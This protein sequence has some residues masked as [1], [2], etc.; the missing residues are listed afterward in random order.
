MMGCGI[1]C[2]AC[3]G[4]GAAEIKYKKTS[5]TTVMTVTSEPHFQICLNAKRFMLD[6]DTN[7]DCIANEKG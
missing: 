3:A 7:I 5:P 1:A 4:R 6:V 2:C